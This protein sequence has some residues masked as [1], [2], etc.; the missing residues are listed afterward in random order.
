MRKN[1]PNLILFLFGIIILFSSTAAVLEIEIRTSETQTE[2]DLTTVEFRSDD[3]KMPKEIEVEIADTYVERYEG[4]GGRESVGDTDG[5]LFVHSEEKDRKYVMRDMK[6][7]VDIL[8]IG[9]DC[10]INSIKQAEEPDPGDSGIEKRHQYNGKSKYVI[11]VPI[12]FL[13]NSGIKEGDTIEIENEDI[14]SC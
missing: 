2:S 14:D 3:G 11:E 7:G 6:F 13:E 12:G 1:I 10:E 5:M 4:L 8:F 9:S